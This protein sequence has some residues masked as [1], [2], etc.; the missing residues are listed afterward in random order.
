MSEA[1]E[2]LQEAIRKNDLNGVVTAIKNGADVTD[3]QLQAAVSHENPNE[4]ITRLLLTYTSA[5]EG[6]LQAAVWNP[7]Q[8]PSVVKALVDDGAPVADRTIETAAYRQNA[9]IVALVLP[10]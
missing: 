9:D 7:N 8:K 1:N 2:Q 6:A 4:D 3:Q 10:H 5:T